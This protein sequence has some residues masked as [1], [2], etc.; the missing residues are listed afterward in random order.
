MISYVIRR[1]AISIVVLLLATIL[2]FLLVAES[3][4]PLALLRAN[5]KIPHST[6]V[7]REKLLNL[8]H[9]LWDRYWI[10][11]SHVV[12]G[13][14]GLDIAGQQVRPLLFSH[15]LVTLRMVIL[16]TLLS[17]VWPSPSVSTPP[18]GRT[19]RPTGWPP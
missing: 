8:N 5:P 13:N 7:A 16:A 12:Q 10:W 17:I 4:N 18:S 1:L 2:V 11:L 19:S 14:F 3:G 6:I 9:P 15:L